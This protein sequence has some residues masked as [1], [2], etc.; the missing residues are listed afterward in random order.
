MLK[1]KTIALI[2]IW[3]IVCIFLS[4]LDIAAESGMKVFEKEKRI[5]VDG[6]IST[7]L[8]RYADEL[9]GAMEYLAVSEGGKEYESI[10]VLD[11]APK[12]IYDALIKLGVK[13]G[14][15]SLYDANTEKMLPPAGGPVRLL[16]RW[17]KAGKVKK[18]RTENLLYNIKTKKKMANVN[19]LFAGSVKGYFDPESD[20]NVLKASYTKN[21]ISFHDGDDGVLIQHPQ[22][23]PA[24]DVPYRINSKVMPKAGTKIKLIINA[25]FMQ[26]HAFINGRVQGVGFRAFTRRNARRIGGIKGYVKNLEDGR[27]ELVAE[28]HKSELDKLVKK[29]KHG[30][31]TAKVKDV[32]IKKRKFNG[33]Y[34]K[35]KIA[36]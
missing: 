7:Q 15:P 30:P 17:K 12:D 16:V 14:Q 2:A 8:E 11:A 22:P 26:I 36:Y 4:T 25:N 24:D 6:K 9:G 20:N 23:A 5:E 31:R 27:V 3:V 34:K 21:L 10:L 13:K 19:W 29:I 33:K 35:F 32:K 1:L 28:G 18:I